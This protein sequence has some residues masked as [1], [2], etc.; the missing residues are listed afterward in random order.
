MS[1][2]LRV[3][4]LTALSTTVVMVAGVVV[5]LNLF[6]ADQLSSIDSVLDSQHTLLAQPALRA[7]RLQR[8]LLESLASEHL[9]TSAT[10]IRVWQ[11]DRVRIEAGPADYL[12]LPSASPG[13]S[14]TSG[15]ASRYRVLT[16]EVEP[17]PAGGG[18]PRMEVA[19]SLAEADEVYQLLKLRL[20]RLVIAGAILF[21]LAG[22]AAAAGALAPLARLRRAAEGIAGTDDLDVRV[23]GDPAPREVSELAESFDA[24]LGRLRGASMEKEQTLEA[25]RVFAAAAAHELRTPLTSI[26]ANLELLS[27]HPDTEERE[28]VIQDLVSEHRRIVGLLESLR[29]LARGDLTGPEAFERVDLADLVTQGVAGVRRNFPAASIELRLPDDPVMVMGWAEGLRLM[30]DNLVVN[31]AT[32]GR[33]DETGAEIVVGLDEGREGVVLTVSDRGPGIEP[34]EREKV[35]GRFTRGTSAREGGSG[36]GMALAV[37]QTRIHGGSLL[38]GD[39]PGGGAT[40][41]VR[42]PSPGP[43]AGHRVPTE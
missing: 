37:Q 35:L 19:L 12:S 21:G 42:L 31:A 33:R 16:R 13:Y 27:T 5:V 3:A 17:L 9:L 18:Q 36:L 24:M 29:Q 28:A 30:V 8:P 40:V 38:I 4:L 6:R 26:G 22:W 7:A 15:E 43:H 1:L 39:T 14:T 41:T 2:R 11:G 20:R 23:S 32:H 10:A 34:S 25:A